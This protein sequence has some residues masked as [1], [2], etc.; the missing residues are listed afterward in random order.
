MCPRFALGSEIPLWFFFSS[1]PDGKQFSFFPPIVYFWVLVIFL[2]ASATILMS[3]Q[4]VCLMLG[5]CSGRS[6]SFSFAASDI[7]ISS[8]F[9]TPK[10]AGVVPCF[11]VDFSCLFDLNL[12]FS[13][14]VTID[15]NP[16]EIQVEKQFTLFIV[17]CCSMY[18]SRP[19]AGK[20][21]SE[22][23]SIFGG[24]TAVQNE[25]ITFET[26]YVVLLQF[27]EFVTDCFRFE[28]ASQ[29]SRYDKLAIAAFIVDV[30]VSG[31]FAISLF[32]FSCLCLELWAGGITIDANEIELSIDG[33]ALPSSVQVVEIL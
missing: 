20:T 31:F 29:D 22:S 10:V 11:C 33:K 25:I 23:I 21:Q 17:F 19:Q 30:F 6:V 28:V 8:I 1:I 2:S 4:P 14:G 5:G 12:L 32:L 26:R 9:I 3:V 7:P 27:C 24:E 13:A 18:P 15:P 16:I